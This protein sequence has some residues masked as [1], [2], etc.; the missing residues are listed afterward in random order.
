MP[1]PVQKVVMGFFGKIGRLLGYKAF[2][3]KYSGFEG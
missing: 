3:K 2:Y 1:I